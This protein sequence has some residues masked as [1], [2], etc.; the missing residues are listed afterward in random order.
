VR[1]ADVGVAALCCGRCD[2]VAE[3]A[4]QADQEL[5]DRET[6]GGQIT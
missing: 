6:F 3:Q 4:E 2:V 5:P 1:F